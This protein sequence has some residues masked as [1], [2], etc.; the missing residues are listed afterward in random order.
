MIQQVG[1]FFNIFVF[2]LLQYV[3]EKTFKDRIMPGCGF[4][5]MRLINVHLSEPEYLKFFVS[6]H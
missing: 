1:L 5:V 3:L 4:D 6:R 2:Q